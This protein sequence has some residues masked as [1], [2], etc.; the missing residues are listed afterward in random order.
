MRPGTEG[1]VYPY[2]NCCICHA[3]VLCCEA[4]M[5]VTSGLGN[6][7]QNQ[8]WSVWVASVNVNKKFLDLLQRQVNHQQ[9]EQNLGYNPAHNQ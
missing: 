1:V 5:Q 8:V 7:R 6:F 4:K 9:V 3:V 2:C